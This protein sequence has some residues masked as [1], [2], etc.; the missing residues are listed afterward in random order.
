[1][2]R[3]N[4]WPIW[5]LGV[6]LLGAACGKKADD[7]EASC[8]AVAAHFERL[9]RAEA[10]ALPADH[11][12]KAATVSVEA[13]LPKLH[14]SLETECRDEKWPE[15]LR[16]CFLAAKD[17]AGFRAACKDLLDRVQKSGN[18]QPK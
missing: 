11:P 1:M 18:P 10:E 16:R 3:R 5:L 15:E 12:D 6:A 17:A 7:G 2:V 8:K 14:D 9:A 13:L 4:A